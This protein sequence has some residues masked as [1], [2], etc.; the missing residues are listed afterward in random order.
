MLCVF[1]LFFGVPLLAVYW[2][3]KELWIRANLKNLKGEV[4]VITGGASGIGKLVALRLVAEKATV[5][6]WDINAEALT[7]AASEITDKGGK[8]LTQV[9][10]VT[11]PQKV[12][13]A[14]EQIQRELGKTATML[15]NNAGIVSGKKL[16]DLNERQIESTM[17]VNTISHFWTIRAFLPHMIQ[18]RHG[19]IVTIASV[20]GIVGV[21]GL[22]DYCA[23]KSGAFAIDESL[24][25]E[26]NRM[27]ARGGR[28]KGVQTLC[29]CPYYINTGMFDGVQ[30]RFPLLLPIL[31]QHYVV[32]Q[33]VRAIKR[34]DPILVLPRFVYVTYLLR[35]FLPVGLFD[36]VQDFMGAS[37]SMDHFVGRTVPQKKTN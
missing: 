6:L 31:E 7:A 36:W 11:D 1:L 9:V 27:G 18:A 24:R 20:A 2:V 32:D 26:L 4:V 22:N 21:N 37:A 29:V 16:L 30:S 12:N 13:A 5:V 25:M 10:D 3:L 8:C 23:S 14:A 28:G 33:I 15:I 34:S 35:F 17:K 19:H